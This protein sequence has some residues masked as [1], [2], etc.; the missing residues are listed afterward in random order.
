VFDDDGRDGPPGSEF[1]PDEPDPEPAFDHLEPEE[2][3]PPDPGAAAEAKAS[4]TDP[5]VA[6]AFWA[7]VVLANVGVA[8]VSVGLLVAGFRGQWALGGGLVAVGA[9][10]LAL[11]V[12]RVRAF[13]ARNAGDAA[14]DPDAG[15]GRPGAG[16]AVEGDDGR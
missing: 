6:E 4:R 14:P 3:A 16:D 2:P 15:D 12:R 1:E 11:T 7:A 9:A 13:R 5:E 8:G 10:A